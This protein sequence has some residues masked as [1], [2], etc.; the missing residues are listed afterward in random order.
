MYSRSLAHQLSQCSIGGNPTNLCQ[1]S[2]HVRPCFLLSLL[3][4]LSV[5]LLLP[6]PLYAVEQ[7]TPQIEKA[8]RKTQAELSKLQ[9]QYQEQLSEMESLET[10]IT[11][12]KRQRSG[13]PGRKLGKALRR[14]QEYTLRAESL[15]TQMESLRKRESRYRTELR[16][17]YSVRLR[18]IIQRL[19]PLPEGKKRKDL[20]KQLVET[21]NTWDKFQPSDKKLLEDQIVQQPLSTDRMRL[22]VLP[23]DVP[24]EIEA[25]SDLARDHADWLRARAYQI[26]DR[27]QRLESERKLRAR[28]EN[29]ADEISLFDMDLATVAQRSTTTSSSV[30]DPR[31]GGVLNYKSSD[32]EVL[33]P[34]TDLGTRWFSPPELGGSSLEEQVQRLRRY[35]DQLRK[36]A[37]TYDKVA[38]QLQQRAEEISD[39]EPGKK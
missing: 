22:R 25:K 38:R 36:E 30:T 17:R 39:A 4:I 9:H 11:E 14:A 29:F 13:R 6:I 7:S 21:L 34:P 19:D 15:H 33:E 27:I 2:Q 23:D 12:L 5:L 3:M 24:A 18:Q 8:L 32:T 1:R 16:E 28:L 20:L 26:E 31:E 37:D 10:E 35:R